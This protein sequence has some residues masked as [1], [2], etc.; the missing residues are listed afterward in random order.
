MDSQV[1]AIS[2]DFIPTLSHW[3]GE[4]KTEFP[5]MSDHDRKVSELY[6]VLI[7]QMGIANRATF[8]IDMDGKIAMIEEG[9]AALDPAGADTACSRLQHKAPAPH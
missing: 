2:T 6:G 3:A 7:T 5:L 9:S 4:L 1:L 8:V